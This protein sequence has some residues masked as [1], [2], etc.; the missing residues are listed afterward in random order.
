M[1][2]LYGFS[3]FITY[4]IIIIII[5]IIDNRRPRWPICLCLADYYE[6]FVGGDDVR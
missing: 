2:W 6:V 5:I 1:I 4:I 3:Y